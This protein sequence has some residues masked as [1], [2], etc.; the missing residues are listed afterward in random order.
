MGRGALAT[1]P[2]PM[3]V[4]GLGQPDPRATPSVFCRGTYRLFY[5]TYPQ[6]RESLTPELAKA[7]LPEPDAEIRETASPELAKPP[8]PSPG[9]PIVETL[10][11][12]LGVGASEV[13]A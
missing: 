10:T 1:K 11:P 4:N 6:V 13:R 12:Q 2:G 5:L 8:L 9:A 7:L 3:R